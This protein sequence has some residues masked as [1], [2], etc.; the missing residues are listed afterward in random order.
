MSRRHDRELAFV[1]CSDRLNTALTNRDRIRSEQLYLQ[2]TNTLHRMLL[3]K[4]DCKLHRHGV[5][6][7]NRSA[8][9]IVEVGSGR[10][11]ISAAVLISDHKLGKH[12]EVRQR[13]GGK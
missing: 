10:F 2:F 4:L 8:L 5:L 11:V 3:A 6:K 1:G 12:D 13:L 7:G 9:K